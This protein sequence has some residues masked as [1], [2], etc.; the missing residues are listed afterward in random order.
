MLLSASNNLNRNGVFMI[1][2]SNTLKCL[3]FTVASIKMT[4]KRKKMK[5]VN[6]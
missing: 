6:I 5:F 4:A 3:D 2:L 1:T